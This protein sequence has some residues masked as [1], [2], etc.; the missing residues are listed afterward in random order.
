VRL[1]AIVVGS[2]VASCGAE[3][4]TVLDFEFCETAQDSG[5]IRQV[6]GVANVRAPHCG[7][8]L[9][10][11]DQ[12]N[13]CSTAPTAEFR[14]IGASGAVCVIVPMCGEFSWNIDHEARSAELVALVAERG[15]ERGSQL[16]LR[17]LTSGTWR[18]AFDGQV[19]SV[20]LQVTTTGER[21]PPS[22]LVG[23]GNQ[24]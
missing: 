7:T 2:L 5:V 6:A 24:R 22:D 1:F 15:S 3:P 9:C 17:G 21:S 16:V 19:S 18:V 20:R 13:A 12:F 10:E 14:A 8:Q 11:S 23:G 4:A